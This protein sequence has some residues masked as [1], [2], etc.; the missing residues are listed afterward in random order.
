LEFSWRRKKPL[1]SRVRTIL[2]TPLLVNPRCR[3]NSDKLQDGFSGVKHR[4]KS[5]AFSIEEERSQGV[6]LS[7]IGFIENRKIAE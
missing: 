5:Q 7:A 3:A 4:S 2:N 1:P 6:F